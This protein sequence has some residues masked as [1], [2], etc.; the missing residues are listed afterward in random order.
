MFLLKI[1]KLLAFPY[2][3]WKLICLVNAQFSNGGNSLMNVPLLRTN[4]D[5]DVNGRAIR[6]Y[7]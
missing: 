5:N 4:T 3:V 6:V 7:T 2:K 1:L